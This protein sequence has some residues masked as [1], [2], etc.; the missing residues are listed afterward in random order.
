MVPDVYGLPPDQG[1]NSL[2]ASHSA[3][4]EQVEVDSPGV[5]ADLDTP[6]DYARLLAEF[7]G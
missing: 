6:E 3:L 2:L 7:K 5:I 1:L 4:I